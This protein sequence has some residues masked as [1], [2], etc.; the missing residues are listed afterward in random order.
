M[1][2]T[3]SDTRA[4][5]QTD[6]RWTSRLRWFGAEFLVVLTGVLVAQARLLIAVLSG[7]E[8]KPAALILA[9]EQVGWASAFR[10]S[11]YTF[12]ELQST[13]NLRFIRSAEIRNAISAYYY[14]T[15]DNRDLL[16]DYARDRAW[17]Y[18]RNTSHVLSPELRVRISLEQAV[19]TASAA[20]ALKK[21]ADVAHVQGLISEVL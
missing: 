18:A 3:P 7:S 15:I 12:L 16:L 4:G 6:N 17:A 21:L 1:T 10:L 11:P 8:T 5:K 2:A 19:D 20:P 9:I 13:G 14:Q